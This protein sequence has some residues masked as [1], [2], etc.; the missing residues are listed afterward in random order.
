M[1]FPTKRST[2]FDGHGDPSDDTCDGP[3]H[4]ALKDVANALGTEDP[5]TT[6]KRT[7]G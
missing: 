1:H 6:Y 4:C 5:T 2:L 7:F 3:S